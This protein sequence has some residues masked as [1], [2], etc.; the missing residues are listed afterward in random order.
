MVLA[1]PAVL[2]TGVQGTVTTAGPAGTCGPSALPLAPGPRFLVLEPRGEPCS[3]GGLEPRREGLR[4]QRCRSV[5]EALPYRGGPRPIC[6]V[7]GESHGR[8]T[9]AGTLPRGSS[10]S[11][12]A[13]VQAGAREMPE[14]G[15]EASPRSHGNSIRG[16]RWPGTQ[17]EPLG[18]TRQPG[19]RHHRVTCRQRGS[20]RLIPLPSSTRQGR[21]ASFLN[22]LL[23]PSSLQ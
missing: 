16:P 3:Q 6:P 11:G 10:L 9:G 21:T 7:Q 5:G 20:E 18:V 2:R 15:G 22:Y 19:W 13:G 17:W 4:V 14:P 23:F 8:W 1:A 12:G